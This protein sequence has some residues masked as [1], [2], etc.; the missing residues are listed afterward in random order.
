MPKVEIDYTQ[1]II[2]K[3]CCKDT[4]ITDIYVGHTTNFTKRKNQHKTSCSNEND[5][6]YKQYVYEF[7]RQNGGWENWT[8]LQI[9]NIKCKD[10]REAEAKEHYWIEYLNS[11]LNSNKPYAKCKEEPK[12]YK[13]DWYED[14]KDY[15]LEKAKNN[16]E[17]NKEQKIKYQT[18]YAQEN[19]EKISEYHKEYRKLNKETLAEKTKIYREEHK[20]EARISQKE[21]REKNKEILKEK[22]KEKQGEIVNCECGHQYTFGNRSRHFQSKVH[23]QFT[24]QISD[25][26]KELMEQQKKEQKEKSI[27]ATKV[28]QGE[29]VNCE[30]GRQYTFGNRS[31]HFQTKVHLQYK[32]QSLESI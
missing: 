9:E 19:K 1:T 21:W 30:C 11:R 26:Q 12:L 4:L 14:N 3:I 24:E 5:K 25:Y 17:E 6:K 28:K 2:Y 29:I 13:H 23:L 27:E 7:I 31:R 16:Y 15:I 8:M 18:Q 22:A 10:K 32:E 20:E